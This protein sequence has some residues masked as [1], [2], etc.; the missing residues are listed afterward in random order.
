MTVYIYN[1][2]Y[3][4]VLEMHVIGINLENIIMWQQE[5]NENE[6]KLTTKSIFRQENENKL[7]SKTFSALGAQLRIY[8][9]LYIWY[10]I[11]LWHTQTV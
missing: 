9:Y 5:E 4:Q 7:L 10:Y 8:V 1:T 11:L 2:Y 6:K 3:I